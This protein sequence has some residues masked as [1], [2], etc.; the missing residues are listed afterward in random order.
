MLS[1]FHRFKYMTKLQ[2]ARLFLLGREKITPA[3]STHALP[4]WHDKVLMEGPPPEVQGKSKKGSQTLKRYGWSSFYFVFLRTGRR[5]FPSFK[6][7]KGKL[8]Q[9]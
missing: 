8:L 4:G 9:E 2:W 5:T 6:K 1:F 7:I 3:L